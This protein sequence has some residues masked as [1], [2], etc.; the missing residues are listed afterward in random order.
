MTDK[1][2]RE[3]SDISQSEIKVFRKNRKL[4]EYIFIKKLGTNEGTKATDKGS[5]NHTLLFEEQEFHNRYTHFNGTVPNSPQMK[6]FFDYMVTEDTNTLT[7]SDMYCNCYSTKSLKIPEIITKSQALYNELT[8]YR[9]FMR[10]SGHKEMITPEIET[11]SRTMIDI[12]LQ[13][14]GVIKTL[15][16]GRNNPKFKVYKEKVIRWVYNG[17]KCKE[18]ADEIHVDIENRIIYV[19]DYKTT[20]ADNMKGFISAIKY[21]GYDTQDSF[22][23]TGVNHWAEE[24]FGLDFQIK[25][26]FIPQ[27]TNFPY[28][29]L[30]V[31]EISEDDREA[32]YI[33]WTKDIEELQRCKETG[34][35]DNPAAYSETGVNLIK[36]NNFDSVVLADG[37]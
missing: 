21:Y 8:E 9:N 31:V 7:I 27:N 17:I 32:A 14:P 34:N 10:D 6:K 2:Y 15:V 23:S 4:Y 36:L 28:N 18:K 26:R 19:Y 12:C 11:E 35:F 29:V 16:A 3:L 33:E 5:L 20:K 1:E 37:F 13:H 25:F 22:Y 30:D 24:T